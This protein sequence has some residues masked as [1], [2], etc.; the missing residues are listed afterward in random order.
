MGAAFTAVCD[1]FNCS[2]L[3][4]HYSLISTKKV[5]IRS[6]GNNETRFTGEMINF[7]DRS[8]ALP[9]MK[10]SLKENGAEIANYTLLPEEYLDKSLHGIQ[11]IPKS[12]PF[13]FQFSLPIARKSFDNYSIE[14]IRP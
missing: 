5:K 4:E 2:R 14:L 9:N 11:R 10:I 3:E 7:H 12:S 13:K 6:I 1:V 8:L